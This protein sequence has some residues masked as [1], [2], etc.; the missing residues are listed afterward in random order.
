MVLS[1]TVILLRL[2]GYELIIT[3]TVLRT[4]LVID[5]GSYLVDP[6]GITVNIIIKLINFTL[7]ITLSLRIRP[8]TV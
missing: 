2:A 3:N 5:I 4:L 7:I 8:F 6:R 1:E